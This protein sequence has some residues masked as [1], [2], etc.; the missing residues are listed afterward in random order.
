MMLVNRLV[1]L[2]KRSFQ[3]LLFAVFFVSMALSA[4]VHAGKQTFIPIHGDVMIFIPILPTPADVVKVTEPQTVGASVHRFS[5]N[6]V[7]NA[8]YYQLD[9]TDENGDVSTVITYSPE[10]VLIDL[11]LGSS[12]VTLMACNSNNQCG[13]H[14]SLGT[15]QTDSRVFYAHTDALGSVIAETNEAGHK[16]NDHKY[17][18]FGESKGSPNEGSPGFTGHL[19]D[20]D[21]GLTYMKARFYDPKLGRFLST[22]PVKYTDANPVFS[23][24]RYAYANNNPYKYVDPDGRFIFQALFVAGLFAL[25]IALTVGHENA[26]GDDSIQSL[27]EGAALGVF[28][29]SAKLLGR[30]G[31]VETVQRWMSRAELKATQDTGL[32]RGGRDGTHYITDATNSNAK[33]ARQRS[34][35]PQTPEVKV[36]LDVP[37]GRFSQSSRVEPAFNMPGGGMERT[38]TGNIPVMIKRVQ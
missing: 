35:L 25:D 14:H 32:L 38:A 9:I 23:F 21:L 7:N 19:Y 12:T 27:G 28:G 24:N 34:A 11:P 31:E 1:M 29:G 3:S 5:W 36:T 30:T 13:A 26:P 10:L 2:A 20:D 22:D 4:S 16:I 8:T 37:K 15:F 33:R 6:A 17:D 18:P